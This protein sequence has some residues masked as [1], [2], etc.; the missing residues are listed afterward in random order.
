MSR[1]EE[2]NYHMDAR[3]LA[4]MPSWLS[5]DEG[6]ML[7]VLDAPEC[8]GAC[9]TPPYTVRQ[10]SGGVTYGSWPYA[11]PVDPSIRK[12]YPDR[13]EFGYWQYSDTTY[14]LFGPE[15][16]LAP[17][18]H[19]PRWELRALEDRAKE[20]NGDWAPAEHP[21]YIEIPARF[22]VCDLCRG[23]GSHV[24]P[25]IDA[26]GLTC[27]DFDQDPDFEEDYRSGRYDV[28]CNECEGRRVV[29]V[30]DEQ[31]TDPEILRMYED[32]LK[33]DY[34]YRREC[35]AERAMGA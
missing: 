34:D 1:L 5:F 7:L 12:D 8:E 31:R 16:S 4:G 2:R 28:P 3:T 22:E 27:D 13:G 19:V 29:P 9:C 6:R 14:Y 21:E 33:D 26:S 17:V 15:G 35:A 18:G 20:L 30:P 23:R 25:S 32:R 10:I 24:N 11:R